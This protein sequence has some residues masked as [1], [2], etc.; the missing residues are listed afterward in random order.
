MEAYDA[1]AEDVE[2]GFEPVFDGTLVRS[3]A[4]ASSAC[5]SGRTGSG[6]TSGR[7]G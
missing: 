2:V 4:R 7:R 5:A 1:L 3:S 6:A